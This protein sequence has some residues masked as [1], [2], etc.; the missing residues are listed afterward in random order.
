MPNDKRKRTERS[1]FTKAGRNSKSGGRRRGQGGLAGYSEYDPTLR[2]QLNKREQQAASLAED[3]HRAAVRQNEFRNAQAILATSFLKMPAGTSRDIAELI[4]KNFV[5]VKP[6][7]SGHFIEPRSG[8]KV[9]R[10][11]LAE[12]Q[13]LEQLTPEQ[14]RDND[15]IFSASR[16]ARWALSKAFEQIKLTS[17]SSISSTST[18]KAVST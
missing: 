16:D 8:K 2:V 14:L 10:T 12:Q 4:I 17:I 9:T 18:L 5:V 13:I 3:K 7:Q 15:A 11:I 6:N 1:G